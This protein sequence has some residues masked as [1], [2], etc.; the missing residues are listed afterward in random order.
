MSSV[1]K[2]DVY[3]LYILNMTLTTKKIDKIELEMPAYMTL[4]YIILSQKVAF[5]KHRLNYGYI[6]IVEKVHNCVI[7]CLG[8]QTYTTNVKEMQRIA[9]TMVRVAVLSGRGGGVG[10]S[11]E[12]KEENKGEFDAGESWWF[13]V[14]SKVERHQDVRCVFFW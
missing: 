8:V 1:C 12:I 9:N 10:K 7:Y 6:H 14:F 4:K 5:G 11:V 2:M 3:I 13:W